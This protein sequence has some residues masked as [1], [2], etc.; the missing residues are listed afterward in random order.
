MHIPKQ[1]GTIQIS[2]NTKWINKL[3]FIH[4]LTYSSAMNRNKQLLPAT[5][6]VRAHKHNVQ[7]KKSDTRKYILYDS[8]YRKVKNR[9]SR[10]DIQC[11]RSGQILLRGGR[12][13][14][15]GH[16]DDFQ[17]PVNVLFLDLVIVTYVCSFYENALEMYICVYVG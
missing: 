7:Q 13:N 10:T 15:Q 16:K 4:S 17:S 11:Q 14:W 8:V 3:C 1:L 6:Q 12:S 5:I 9:Q 2:I